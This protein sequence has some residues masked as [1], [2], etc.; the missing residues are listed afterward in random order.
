MKYIWTLI[1]AIGISSLLA[2]IVYNSIPKTAFV[3]NHQLFEN[4]EGRKELEQRLEQGANARKTTLDSLSLQIQQI[5]MAVQKDETLVDRFRS[6]QQQYAQLNQEH[7]TLYQQKSQ[8][9]T[10]AI[11]KQISQYTITY[12]EEKGYDYVFGI[13]GQGTLMYGKPQYNITED[14]IQYINSKYAGN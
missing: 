13:A 8:E 3:N 7:Q 5:Q 9:Y 1:L 14:V 6:L 11:W 10:E 12:G 2:G 4:F